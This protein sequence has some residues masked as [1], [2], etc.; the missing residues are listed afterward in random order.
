MAKTLIRKNM[1]SRK[2]VSLFLTI[3]IFLF[4]GCTA[5]QS[6]NG[7]VQSEESLI[8]EKSTEEL[9]QMLESA[10]DVD[11]PA[12][13]LFYDVI[14]ELEKRGQSASEAAPVL[15]K[16]MSYNRR[17]SVVAGEA[18]IPMRQSAASAIPILLRNLDN[19]RED[20]R[21]YSI[22]NLGFIGK[23][24]ECSIPKLGSLLWDKDPGVRSASAI[25][26]EALTGIDLVRDDEELDPELY[27]SVNLDDPE[28]SVT[29][30]AREWW[31]ET[32]SNLELPTENCDLTN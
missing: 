31:Q 14:E 13:N 12:F 25:V 15:A 28:G 17:D 2:T 9:I 5:T 3:L 22:F 11:G 16:A 23:P 24:A 7:E 26:I 20:V 30:K 1:T 8:S 29:R 10:N 21:R 18:L 32:G 27:G 4:A 19:E 6:D